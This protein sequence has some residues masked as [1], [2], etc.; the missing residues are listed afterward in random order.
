MLARSDWHTFV[1]ALL[2]REANMALYYLLLRGWIHIG[3]TEAWL[4]LL[5]VVFGVAAVPIM[6]Q[7][8]QALFGTR[9]AR[10]A[11]FLMTIHV[12][13]IQYSQEVRGYALV[14]FLALLSC[15]FF[16]RLLASATTTTQAAYIL[17]SVLMIYAHVFGAWILF[18]QWA[19]TLFLPNAAN[20]KKTVCIAAGIISVFISPLVF[21]LL[22]VSDRSQLSWMIQGTASSLYHFLL[23]LSGSASDPLLVLYLVLLLVSLRSHFRSR[24]HLQ[25][26]TTVAYGFIWVWLLL[27]TFIVG[28]IS[29]Y[30]PILQA[31]YL[32]VCLPAF[33]ILA[34]DGLAH[35]RSRPIFVAALIAMAGLSLVGLN[36]YY[37]A[38]VDLN[39]IDN[40][41]D[42]TSYCLSQAQSGDAVLFTYSAEEI[43]FREYQ[44][45]LGRG[46]SD[47][48]LVPQKTD[49]ELL[50]TVGTWASSALASSTAFQNHRVW[51]I[52]AL[53]PNARSAEAQAALRTQLKEE[54]RRSFGFVTTQLFVSAN[55]AAR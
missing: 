40:W 26:S 47:I 17:A 5:S 39:H 8:A 43:P 37:K 6:Y 25:G 34:A 46:G 51:V 19:Y 23:D 55:R 7:L 35:I 18:A 11:A 42:A 16:V 20:I 29:L 12:F 53:Q 2:R 24:R 41:R 48:T 54:S 31:R 9:T 36:S 3:H 28:S 33:L 45:R 50:S 13:H 38:R 27:P 52:T 44:N 21:S 30:R 22:F 32:I 4:R 14:V 10:I 15:Y 49:L 1:T